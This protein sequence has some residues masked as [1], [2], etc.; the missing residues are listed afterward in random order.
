MVNLHELLVIHYNTEFNEKSYEDTK[1]LSC[2]DKQYMKI[3]KDSANIVDGH[4]SLR[5]PF[6]KDNIS[7]PDNCHVAE[8]RLS[9]LKRKFPRIASFHEEYTNFLND[10]INKGYAEEV[11]QGQLKRNDGKVWYIPHHG[12]YHPKKGK[13]RVIF[14]CGASFNGTSLK[15]EL[16]QGPDLANRLIGDSTRNQ[17]Q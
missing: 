8:Q 4:Y 9:S 17:L 6:R 5:L 12:V 10:V 2:E 11:S 14:D 1:D 15:S 16:L 3:V 13:L 7:L